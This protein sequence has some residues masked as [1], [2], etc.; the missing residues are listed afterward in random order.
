VILTLLICMRWEITLKK[1]LIT[2]VAAAL[3]GGLVLVSWDSLSARFLEAN[4]EEELDEN[5]F[6]NRGQYI[7]LVKEIMKDRSFGVGLNNWSYW[8]SKLYGPRTGTDYRDYDS[9]LEDLLR[10]PK[11]VDIGPNFAPPAHNLGIITLGEL[12]LPGLIIFSLLWLRWFS[13]GVRFLWPRLADPM[14]RIGVGL[15]FGTCGI[16]LQSLTEWVYRETAILLTFHILMGTLASLCLHRKRVRRA[17]HQHRR[18]VLRQRE[19]AAMR[20]Q[21]VPALSAWSGA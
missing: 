7:G 3:M 13:M 4:L 1:I 11:M 20:P 15:F 6:E 12:G 19:Q 9:V 2:T 16:F 8:V 21:P 5:K 10:S 17:E 18:R 14:Y